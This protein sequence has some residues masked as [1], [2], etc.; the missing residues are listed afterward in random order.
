MEPVELQTDRLVLRL[1]TAVDEVAVVEA[2]NDPEITHYLPLPVPYTPED[3]RSFIAKSAQEWVDGS[4][5]GFGFFLGGTGELAG[6]CALKT[7]SP[8]V[9]EVGYWSAAQHRRKGHTAEAIRRLCQ[10][11]FDALA[12]HRIEWWAIVGNHGSRAVAEA[13][14]FE[15]EG[16]L[17]Q[18]A[19]R[20]EEPADWWVGGLLSRP[21]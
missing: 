19:Y 11:G 7:I 1:V 17:R 5:Y 8:G 12:I 9:V 13:V 2:C 18:R 16:L 4:R 6:T 21:E 14:G 20:R 3:A 15:M 10:W